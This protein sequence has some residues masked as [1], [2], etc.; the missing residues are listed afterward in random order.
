MVIIQRIKANNKIGNSCLVKQTNSVSFL[1]YSVR[2]YKDNISNGSSKL[3][4][5][6]FSY[7]FPSAFVN[8][9]GLVQ[10]FLFKLVIVLLTFDENHI[11]GFLSLNLPGIDPDFIFQRQP[12]RNLVNF[13]EA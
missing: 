1:K 6:F 4:R 11:N 7:F 5:K 8:H 9:E 10:A 12:Y 2:E 3:F 13:S